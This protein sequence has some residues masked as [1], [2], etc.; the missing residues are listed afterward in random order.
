MC[1]Q[2]LGSAD[3]E[4]GRKWEP[5]RDAWLISVPIMCDSWSQ[6]CEYKWAPTVEPARERNYRWIKRSKRQTQNTKTCRKS[7][8]PRQDISV[9]NVFFKMRPKKHKAWK[10]WFRHI[11]ESHRSAHPLIPPTSGLDI[12]AGQGQHS[13]RLRHKCSRQNYPPSLNTGN[14]PNAHQLTNEEANYGIFD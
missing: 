5:Y 8:R 3:S 12:H 9:W 2:E 11:S 1:Y 14:A 10:S 13:K 4:L 6:G 7:F